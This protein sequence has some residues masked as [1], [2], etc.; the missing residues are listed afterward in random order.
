MVI[1]LSQTDTEAGLRN[2]SRIIFVEPVPPAPVL[3][4]KFNMHRFKNVKKY[5]ITM[6]FPIHININFNHKA[7]EEKMVLNLRL[8]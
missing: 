1:K 8:I 2:R 3:A 5:L 7:S 6:K 4:L